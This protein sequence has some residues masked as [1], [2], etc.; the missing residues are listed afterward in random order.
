LLA[1]PI[2]RRVETTLVSVWVALSKPAQVRL[3]VWEGRVATGAPGPLFSNPAPGVHTLRVGA[4]LHLAQVTLKVPE[5]SVQTLQADRLYSYD[6]EIAPDGQA[7][8]ETLASLHMLEAGEFDGQA[9]V[10]LG[11]EPG[12]LPS[13]APPPSELDNLRIVYGSCRRAAHPDPDAM[14]WLD[15]L[16]ADDDAYKDAR[17]RPHQLFLGGDQIYAD[18]VSRLHM[19]LVMNLSN[20]LVG[21]TGPD[22]RPLE[23]ISLGAILQRTVAEAAVDPAK[24]LASYADEPAETTHTLGAQLPADRRFF[25]EGGRL[26]L[27]LRAAQLTSSDGDSHLISFGEFAAMYLS[28]WSPALWGDTVPGATLV[29]DPALGSTPRPLR[30]KDE[31]TSQSV[32]GMPAPEFPDRLPKHLYPDPAD[33]TPKQ[34]RKEKEELAR[35]AKLKPEE[36]AAEDTKAQ[37]A[38]AAQAEEDKV[39]DQRSLREQLRVLNALREGLPKVRRAMANIPTYMVFDDH[40]VTDDWNLNPIWRD[41]VMTNPLGV[42]IVRNALLS[43]ALFQ[44]WGNDP[45]KY[46]TGVNHREL[47]VQAQQVF[48]DGLEVG[49]DPAAASALDHLFGFDLPDSPLPGFVPATV[50]PMTWHFSVDGPKHR[51]I[52]LD[53]RT[54]RSFASREGP[55]GNVSIDAQ[56]VQVPLPPLAPDG[57]EV[58]IVI[59]P[60]QVIGPPLLDELVAPLSYRIFDALSVRKDDSSLGPNSK[61]GLRGMV[62]TNPDAIEAWAFDAITFEALLKR[63]STYPR[64]VLLSG[65][66]HYSASSLMS[67]WKGTATQPARIAQ[68]TSSGF[69]NVMPSYI[70]LVDRSLGFAQQLVRAKLGIERIGWDRPLNDLVLLPQG[71]S[72]VDLVPVMRARLQDVPVMVPTWG[73]PNDNAAGEDLAEK[74]SRLN[75]ALP[76][77]WRWRVAPLLDQRADAPAETQPDPEPDA[78][79]PAAMRPLPL[80]LDLIDQQLTPPSAT[81]PAVHALDAYAA[82]AAR[83]QRAVDKL[84]NARQ[85]LFRSNFGRV[86]FEHRGARLFAIHELYTAFA[87]IDA[88]APA[89]P[90]PAAFMR[91]EASLGPDDEAPPTDLRLQAIVP[92]DPPSPGVQP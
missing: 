83:H 15:D 22:T 54:R 52:V 65:D 90:K 78:H 82:I 7:T 30:W 26:H 14:A 85:M 45:Q 84:N 44:D 89:E 10:P 80:N 43:Y 48:R 72:D 19:L 12:L 66:V 37:A 92:I 24:P 27:T 2:L 76:P 87:D 36:L 1:G 18:D 59:A 60:L 35:R 41:R 9:Q 53:N 8:K 49:P 28:V 11:Y 33:R 20:V 74:K 23:Q 68:F 17:R 46:D 91:H 3:T 50:P 67:Y 88:T 34:L 56:A 5:N 57:R 86:S 42:T 25:P 4:Q 40:D 62:G 51:V 64:V 61:S 81:A 70:R 39:K 31:P 21:T 58:L 32:I 63:L 77:D 79:R 13:F 69:K 38:A 73:W 55:P 29:P 16:V 47:M 71:K 6:L 75:P